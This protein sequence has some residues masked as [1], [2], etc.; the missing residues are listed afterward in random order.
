MTLI[1]S[2]A[3]NQT[4][5]E[6]A[7]DKNQTEPVSEGIEKEQLSKTPVESD[8]GIGNGATPITDLYIKNIETAHR[9]TDFYAHK[10]ISFDINIFFGGK[11]YFVGKTTMLTNSTKIRIDKN[12]GSTLVYDG[13]KVFLSPSDANDKG[14]RF[15]MF[16]WTYFFGLPYKLDDPGTSLEL[17]QMRTLD[18]VDHQTAKLTFG[19]NI[20]DS[21]DDWYIVYS[22][23]KEH[24][25]KAA[26]YIVTFGSNGNTDKAESDPH[27]IVYNDF[28]EIEGIPIATKWNFYGWTHEKGVT[29]P[30]GE[31]TISNIKFLNEENSLF[32]VPVNSKEINL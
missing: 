26:S 5:Q 10:A 31:A 17:Q 1:I 6:Q 12:D 24:L 9:K 3:C 11:T 32:D 16:T 21:P 19:K 22:D 27:V 15:N 13:K 18:G 14:A 30:L 2:C 29:N 20:G 4:K 8:N 25:L 28:K 23:P 7:Q